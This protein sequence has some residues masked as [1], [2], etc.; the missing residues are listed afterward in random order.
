MEM[1]WV[2]SKKCEEEIYEKILTTE[3]S[4]DGVKKI[5]QALQ[6][7]KYIVS[8]TFADSPQSE[9]FGHFLERFW[10][11]DRSPYFAEKKIVGQS[12]HR[13]YADI[14]LKR[15][16]AYWIPS[17]GKIPLGEITLFDIKKKLLSLATT[18]QK[19]GTAKKDGLGNQIFVKR[20]LRAETVNQIVRCAT[21]ALKWAYHNKLT[22]NDC[23]SG[24]IWCHVVPEKRVV[25]TMSEVEQIFSKK[26][27]DESIRLAHLISICTGMRIGE[28]QALQ[29][30]DI[31]SDRIFV[32]HN[33]T[34][35]DG[36]KSPKNGCQREIIVDQKLLSLIK[37][38]AEKNPFGPRPSNFLFWGQTKEKPSSYSKW[39]RELHGI[40]KNL[41]IKDGEKITFHCWRHFFSTTMAD[42]VD[43][44]KLQLATGHK[45]IAMLEHYAAHQSEQTL[46]ELAQTSSKIF[47]PILGIC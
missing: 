40:V 26:W 17:H 20:K 29:L 9:T 21:L 31:G 45:S 46:M 19:V 16:R 28:V 5:V 36:L 3:I 24:I 15:A 33:W 11:F 8:A 23:F 10:D 14:M 41:N 4:V 6:M 25:P 35:R 42:S 37:K 1:E 32:R 34:R 2:D 47:A 39:N 22:K 27:N 44:R 13:R 38:Q 30:G 43:L 12:A 7:K 18:A